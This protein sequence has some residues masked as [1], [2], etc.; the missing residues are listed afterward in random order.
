MAF[1]LVYDYCLKISVD[2]AHNSLK[3]R[4]KKDINHVENYYLTAMFGFDWC[5]IELPV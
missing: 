4:R 2:L 3:I 1:S 5:R